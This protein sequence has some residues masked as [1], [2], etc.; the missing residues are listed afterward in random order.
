MTPQ[1]IQR[2]LA[3]QVGEAEAAQI[4]LAIDEIARLETVYFPAKFR[5]NL[6]DQRVYGLCSGYSM[7]EVAQALGISERRVRSAYRRELKRR[8]HPKTA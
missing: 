5:Q 1:D 4:M 8:R 6:E 7:V 3:K 2:A